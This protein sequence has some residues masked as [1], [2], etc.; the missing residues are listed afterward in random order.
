M[1]S[2]ISVLA[3]EEPDIVALS[4]A[5]GIVETDM[6][7]SFRDLAKPFMNSAQ[8]NQML[9]MPAAR[10]QNIAEYYAKLVLA[11]PKGK[12]GVFANI[13]ESWIKQLIE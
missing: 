3:K 10:P 7:H 9:S 5:P 13:S 6:M 1:N 11:A 12:S 8:I 2:I 4:I